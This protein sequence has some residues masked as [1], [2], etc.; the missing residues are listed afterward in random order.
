MLQGALRR[1]PVWPVL[2][3]AS[4]VFV[5][6]FSFSRRFC[7]RFGFERRMFLRSDQMAFAAEGAEGDID[8]GLFEYAFGQRSGLFGGFGSLRAEGL[9]DIPQGVSAFRGG[10]PPAVA[11][12]VEALGQDVV[13][14]APGEL[15]GGDAAQ[16]LAVAVGAVAPG[17]DDMAV[18]HLLYAAVGNGDLV[19]VA[20]EIAQCVLGPSG[21]LLG[22]CHPFRAGKLA[23]TAL[24]VVR[25]REARRAA[26]ERE[27]PASAQRTQA[28][29]ESVAEGLGEGVLAEEPVPAA[30]YPFLRLLPP[31]PARHEAVDVEMP[32]QPLVP[33]VQ[34][35]D[36]AE[37]A[38]E[39]PL[40]I[41]REALQNPADDMEELVEQQ[42]PV[43]VHQRV[44]AVR[45]SEDQMEI[46]HRKD[47]AHSPSGPLAAR[48]AL[49]GRA[50][51]VLAGVVDWQLASAVVAAVD[52]PAQRG[53]PAQQ[54]PAHRLRRV[55]R[56]GPRPVVA[57]PAG[58]DR[59]RNPHSDFHR[60]RSSQSSPRVSSGLCVLRI[61]SAVT[62]M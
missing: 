37:L 50:V 8:A 25:V 29:Y 56:D 61:I 49:A 38:F 20:G 57:V 14:E 23:E 58:A 48:M 46:L 1:S 30:V 3:L 45:Q 2:S 40:R 19:G 34:Q 4:I 6:K 21:H 12:L 59:V 35:G 28:L 22:V 32:Q 13:E 7:D 10:H 33:G 42:L 39:P 24:P 5:C 60:L 55:R 51:A 18:A 53:R 16:L 47:L 54:H 26:G 15:F 31:D 43:G 27:L 9:A 44:Q 17:E 62:C 11:D 41:V 36:V 52:V